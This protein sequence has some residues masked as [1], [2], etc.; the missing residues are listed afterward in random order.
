MIDWVFGGLAASA[1]TTL[2]RWRGH[3]ACGVC[4]C[5]GWV[6]AWTR[7]TTDAARGGPATVLGRPVW[8]H[9]SAFWWPWSAPFWLCGQVVYSYETNNAMSSIGLSVVSCSRVTSISETPRRAS[10][11]TLEE[12]CGHTWD[13]AQATVNVANDTDNRRGC[14]PISLGQ[15][16][17]GVR[18]LTFE[19]GAANPRRIRTCIFGLPDAPPQLSRARRTESTQEGCAARAECIR[20]SAGPRC[21]ADRAQGAV[22]HDLGVDGADVSGVVTKPKT[23]TTRQN[24]KLSTGHVVKKQQTQIHYPRQHQPHD[25]PDRVRNVLAAPTTPAL[26]NPH[27]NTRHARPRAGVCDKPHQPRL[28]TPTPHRKAHNHDT[29]NRTHRHPRPR[30]LRSPTH[31]L[32]QQRQRRPHRQRLPTNTPRNHTNLAPH[33]Q[34]PT[35]PQPAQRTHHLNQ[36]PTQPHHHTR[37]QRHQNKQQHSPNTTHYTKCS[38]PC[39]PTSTEPPPSR[40]DPLLPIHLTRNPPQ[41]LTRITSP[42][43]QIRLPHTT[44]QR[45]TNRHM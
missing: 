19:C 42:P 40:N 32:H 33:H 37:R 12:G 29:A 43:H 24:T 5:E 44:I 4:P 2:P 18:A 14:H 9:Q 3:A 15:S 31:H 8:S 45:S 35:H 27:T 22:A 23:H 28:T 41:I 38:P 39:S 6:H 20:R 13:Q 34:Q 26:T 36:H 16:D 21:E 25:T 11:S 17:V 1:S 7:P 30:R 10:R